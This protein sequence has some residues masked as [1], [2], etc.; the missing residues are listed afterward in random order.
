MLE[1]GADWEEMLRFGWGCWWNGIVEWYVERVKTLIPRLVSS[2][3]D[4]EC[5]LLGLGVR[6]L[7]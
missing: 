3:Y 2:L 7:F 1:Q 4:R 5:R 6:N